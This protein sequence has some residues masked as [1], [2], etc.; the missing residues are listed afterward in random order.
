M[1]LKEILLLIAA[2]T[3]VLGLTYLTVIICSG[4]DVKQDESQLTE[5]L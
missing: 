4:C 5:V 3:I 1:K 2:C